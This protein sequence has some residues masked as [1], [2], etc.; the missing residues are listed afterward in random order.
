MTPLPLHVASSDP[1]TLYPVTLRRIS[2]ALMALGY[3]PD[4]AVPQG[5]IRLDIEGQVFLF[6]LDPTGR[7]LS[8]RNVWDTDASFDETE[9]FFFLA[10]DTWNRERYFPT[11]YTSRSPVGTTQVV[12]DYVVPCRHGLSDQQLID[13]VR[14]G[15]ATGSDAMR[16]MVNAADDVLKT[17]TK[18][19][20][21]HD[22]A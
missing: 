22:S 6:S 20:T 1:H 17:F 7:Q 9:P 8:I 19:I 2:N 21:G 3:H 14:V 10:A 15:I 4:P 5:T 16:F 18:T 13:S 11:V 12:A